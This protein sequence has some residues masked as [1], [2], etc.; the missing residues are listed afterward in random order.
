MHSIASVLLH[1]LFNEFNNLKKNS[2]R[3]TE[4]TILYRLSLTF[5]RWKPV[6]TTNGI[7]FQINQISTKSDQWK[8][9][10]GD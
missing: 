10:G 4:K 6:L 2:I 5:N 9:S 7:H 3:F 1:L 8:K